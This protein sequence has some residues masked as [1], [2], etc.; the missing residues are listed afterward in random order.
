MKRTPEGKGASPQC[1]DGYTKVAN[2]TLEA[3]AQVKLSPYEWRVL[4]FIIRKTSGWHKKS[5]YISL[6]Q[7]VLGTGILKTNASRTLRA[8]RLRQI[9]I[10]SDNKHI[11]FNEDYT[12]WLSVAI[13]QKVIS[14]DNGVISSDNKKLSAETPQKKRKET[15]QKKGIATDFLEYAESLRERFPLIDFP[16]QFELCLLHW[17]VRPHKDPKKCLLRWM[18]NAEKW[19]TEREPQRKSNKPFNCDCGR[20]FDTEDE[21]TQHSWRCGR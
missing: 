9:V 21:L 12:Q 7:I 4:V 1:E 3:L 2:K 20:G 19:R 10:S 14:S 5:D 15:I 16:L 13:T 11:G 18:K 17:E 6:S 8:L